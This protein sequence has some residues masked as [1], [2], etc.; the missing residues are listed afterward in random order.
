MLSILMAV[1]LAQAPAEPAPVLRLDEALRLAEESNLDLRMA[2]ERLERAQ[3]LSKKAWA[4]FLPVLSASA[5]AV[6]NNTEI[7][8]DFIGALEPLADQFGVTLPPSEPTIIQ[9]L[10]EKS[11]S[12][13][14]NWPLL[15]GRAIP[16]L[17]NAYDSIEVAGLTFKQTQQAMRHATA[18]AYY[19]VLNAHRQVD[20]RAR[21]LENQRQ[22]L[23]LEQA[24]LAVGDATEV[25]TLRAEVEV[26]AEEQGL[27]QAQNA[28]RI[29][30]RALAVLIGWLEDDGGVRPFSVARPET[31]AAPAGDVLSR[32]LA[33]RLDLKTRIL[34]LDIA[35]RSKTETWMKYAPVLSGIGNYRWS[36]SEGFSGENTT[37][38]VGLA[39]TWTFFEGGLTT[40]E[41][42]ERQHD[43]NLANLNI[44]KA[45]QDITRQVAEARL[46]IESATAAHEAARRRAELARRTA[47]LVDKQ[48]EAGSAS[49]LDVL[50]AS[51]ALADAETAAALAQLDEDVARLTLEQ[52]VV[53]DP[54]TITGGAA[55]TVTSSDLSAAAVRAPPPAA[56]APGF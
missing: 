11:A 22:H 39:L 17:F 2:K 8:F 49:Q 12:I 45:R 46:N 54:G 47:Q 35:E 4:L 32:A 40:W 6:R 37:W 3:V 20:I 50:D 27:I 34:E 19:N 42:D 55:V 36:E 41:L 7:A 29:A 21:A 56:G 23:R 18:L 28:A 13:N 26:A 5:Q 1:A 43:I 30:T 33:E 51:R 9:R 16:L 10:Y 31:P 44:E 48:Y 53:M 25:S 15:N 14:L 38:Q 24:R 52:T